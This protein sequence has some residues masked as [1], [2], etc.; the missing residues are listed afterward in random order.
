MDVQSTV[1]F[2]MGGQLILKNQSPDI[3]KHDSLS[4]LV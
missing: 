2:L 3:Q 1:F 4:Y